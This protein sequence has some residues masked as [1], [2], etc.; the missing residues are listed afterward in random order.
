MVPKDFVE[1]TVTK[2]IVR[3]FHK[4]SL[5]HF[6]IAWF[7]LIILFGGA[8][9]LLTSRTESRL[10]Y[11][12]RLIEKGVDG[13]LNSLYFSFITTTSLGYGDIAPLG[14]AKF[15]AIIEVI[16]GLLM[17][18]AIIA[19]LVSVKE[20][21]ILE[22]V[23]EIQF[24]QKI[25]K[26]RENLYHDRKHISKITE[27][28]KSEKDF[29]EEDMHLM[30]LNLETHIIDIRDFFMMREGAGNEFIKKLDD[31]RLGLLLTSIEVCLEYY[32]QLKQ[33][34]FEKKVDYS[35]QMIA[36][37]IKS[38]ED[39]THSILDKAATRNHPELREK[40]VKIKRY[41]KRICEI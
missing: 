31:Y 8:F 13:F 24:Q 12:G 4:T 35:V 30:F 18:G 15:L 29:S 23:Y 41:L 6:F 5:T 39:A 37:Y 22:D 27:N 32:A 40:V 2:R 7:F 33:C 36:K 26:L 1:Q 3:F 16:M 20:E 38:V 17:N 34:L 10:I 25:D 28:I 14:F 9:Y 19:K 11:Q 21:I